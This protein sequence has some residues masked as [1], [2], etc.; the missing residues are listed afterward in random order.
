MFFKKI[1]IENFRGIKY[2]L[3]DDF[4]RLNIFLGKNNV[5]KSTILESLFLLI[6]PSNPELPIRIN[7]FRSLEIN[8]SDDFSFIF[9]NLSYKNEINLSAKLD[10]NESRELNIKPRN[11][12]SI[13]TKTSEF[14][15]DDDSSNTNSLGDSNKEKI[16]GLSLEFQRAK[17][18]KSLIYNSEI[19]IENDKIKRNI[20]DDYKESLSGV[21]ILP[22]PKTWNLNK[23][24]EHL[25]IN[26]KVD[27]IVSV[28]KNI[29]PNI[30]S[31]SLGR[32]DMIYFDLGLDRLVPS[33][34]L[35]D[36]IRRLLSILVT[37][38]DTPG[39]V[40]FIDEIDFGLHHTTQNVLWKSVIEAAYKF[41]CQIFATT[42]SSDS[43][44]SLKETLDQDLNLFNDKSDISIYTLRKNEKSQ[45]QAYRY[46]KYE[47][48]YAIDQDT[49]LR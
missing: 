19:Y 25:I 27:E 10:N 40:I 18:G 37:I 35:G 39:G 21:Y 31:I 36:G 46:G 49:E 17:D 26:K 2:S 33:N 11:K 38:S 43:L 8:E 7:L 5:G 29:D 12:D 23:R 30:K 47:F 20:P 3:I 9:Y 41:D 4:G 16:N 34:V 6:N 22:F 14:I 15:V 48:N 24:L 1:S 44:L 28:L 42:H 45:V 32:N 13:N